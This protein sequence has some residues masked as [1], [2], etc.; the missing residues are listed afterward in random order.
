[1]LDGYKRGGGQGQFAGNFHGFLEVAPD[2]IAIIDPFGKI[3][4][5]N[6][7]AE[8]LFGYDRNDILGHPVEVL[9]PSRYRERHRAHRTTYNDDMDQRPMGSG[10][11][12]VG[13][14]KNGNEFPI[15]VMLSPL[16][17][18]AGTFIAC[19]VRDMTSHRKSEDELRRK[20]EEL[21][22][23]DR[24]KDIFIAV[25]MHELKGPLGAITNVKDLL[26][27][28]GIGSA[29]HEIA[30]AI[31]KR[32]I[33]HMLRLVNDLL[34]VS[35]VRQGQLQIQT[36]LF[37]LR[38]I[39]DKAVE[40]T[41][42][43]VSGSKHELRVV[44]SAEPLQI[45]GD[46]T[47]LTQ[48]VS[49]LITNAAKYTPLGGNITITTEQDNGF[50]VIRVHDNG[51]GIAAHMLHRVFHLFAQVERPDRQIIDGM[52][53]GLSLVERL[54]HLHS[55]TVTAASEGLG[56][57]SQFTVTLPMQKNALAASA[58]GQ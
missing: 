48:V 30:I 26:Q 31:L 47:R 44:Q 2:A 52:G 23:A 33:A 9:M 41:H 17:T 5:F 51:E 22:E 54:V 56:Q 4:R 35:K 28:E 49:N 24:Q 36:Q 18:E 12:L 8:R 39:V 50:A 1:M 10:L 38:S 13:L 14:H 42:P 16:H 15:D 20:T 32:Q 45:N 27:M 11:D 7:Q 55:G 43:I 6:G 21:E 40:I 53:I 34:D 57:G 37:D 29:G 25:V 19:A 58:A 46:P 3:V